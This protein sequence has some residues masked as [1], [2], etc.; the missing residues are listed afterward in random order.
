MFSPSTKVL[1]VDDMMTMRKL[2]S[3][4]CKEIGFTDIVE[5]ADGVIAWEAIQNANPPFGLIISDWNMPNC[6]GLDLLKRVRADTKFGKLPFVLVTAEAEQ[7]QI[8][9]AVKAG[10]SSYV[11]KPFSHVTLKEKLEAVHKKITQA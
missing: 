2:V 11:I 1:V 6:T 8:V 10:V 9:E 5:A 7:H 3:K 4:N